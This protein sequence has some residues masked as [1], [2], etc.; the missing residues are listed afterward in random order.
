[1]IVKDMKTTVTFILSSIKINSSILCKF[2]MIFESF[3]MLFN[4]YY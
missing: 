2:P 1:M 4:F 3:F